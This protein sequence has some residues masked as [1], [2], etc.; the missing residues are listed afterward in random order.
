[1]VRTYSEMTDTFKT[2]FARADM[3]QCAFALLDIDKTLQQLGTSA[4]S[5]Y[6]Q[7]KDCERDAVLDRISYLNRKTKCTHCHGVGYV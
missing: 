4:S 6:V 3:A 7:E 2:K 1:M 5:D